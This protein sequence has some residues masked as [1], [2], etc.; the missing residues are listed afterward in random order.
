MTNFP[1]SENLPNVSL[2]FKHYKVGGAVRDKLL[3]QFDSDIQIKEIDWVVVGSST[4]QMLDLGFRQIGKN[5]PVFLHPKTNEEY[6]LAR[7]EKKQG[8]GYAGFTFNTSSKVSLEEDLSRRDLTINAIAYDPKSKKFIDPYNGKKDLLQYTL[9]HISDAFSEDPLRVFRVARFYAR[10]AYLGFNVAPETIEKMRQICQTDELKH[11]S[12]ERVWRETQLALETR[13]PHLFFK[14]M[15]EV[16]GLKYWFPEIHNLFGVPQPPKWH[17]E[18]D[19]GIHTLLVLE[20]ASKLT[21]DITVRFCA[22]T[23]DLGKATTSKEILPSH[24]GHEK[25]GVNLVKNLCERL[26]IPNNFKKLAIYSAQWHTHFHRLNEMRADTYL[27]ML[28]S[29]DFFHH[30]QNL[31]QLMQVS[32]SDS[33][34]RTGFGY[35]PFQPKIFWLNLAHKMKELELSKPTQDPIFQAME[36]T[37]K[38]DYLYKKRLNVVRN[39]LQQESLLIANSE[40]E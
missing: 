35:K 4:Q 15:Y 3:Q 30:P 22:L 1:H 16:G 5:F 17:P 31:I 20:Q 8:H 37:Q 24:R 27:K 11:L 39:V 2:P 38:K 32:E 40:N 36:N 21:N 28:L 25:R 10:F 13:S 23:H 18:I 19:C 6:A 9:R 33:K 26:L 12:A 7:L 14:L 34:G 29:I